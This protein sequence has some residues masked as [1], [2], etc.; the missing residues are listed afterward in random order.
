[1]LSKSKPIQIK[2][3]LLLAVA[4]PTLAFAASSF[5]V[6]KEKELKMGKKVPAMEIVMSATDLETYALNAI[7]FLAKG[8]KLSNKYAST[9]RVQY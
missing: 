2:R 7:E 6:K 8:T 1:M 9:K 4:L 3:L 5:F